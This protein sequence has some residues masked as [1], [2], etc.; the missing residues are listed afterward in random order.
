MSTLP[1]ETRDWLR[2]PGL[3]RLWES[4]R[5]R[6]EANGL[7]ATGSLRL[8]GLDAEERTA[9]SQLLGKTLTGTSVTV[10]LQELD[11]RLRTSAAEAGL[12]ATV[13]ALGQPLI[14]RRAVRANALSRRDQ[15][16]SS[17]SD[18][19]NASPLA[20]EAWAAQWYDG[21]RRSGVPRGVSLDDAVR[22]LHQATGILVLLHGPAGS[23]AR[24]RG[25]IATEATG[26]AHGLDDGTWLARLV[27]RGIALA[28]GAELPENAAGRRALWR[29]AGVTPDEVSSTVLVYGLRPDGADW[30][31]RALR[32]RADHH[33][34]SHLTLRDLHTLDLTMA[35]GTLV[36]IC[37]NPRVLEAAA[38]AA[39]TQPLVCTS[40]SA[41][42]A[43]LTLLDALVA[44]DC[45]FAYHGD[46]DWPGI[47]LANRIIRRYGARPWRMSAEDY[48]R[49]AARTQARGV[50]QLPLTGQPVDADWD[51]DL[52]PTMEALS[53]AL[54]E[55]A[56]L[57][58]LVDDLR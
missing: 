50:P 17:V 20:E 27:Q 57:D 55:E 52:A 54:H 9:V 29:L 25:E 1:A 18:A 3:Q 37:E 58:L 42:T 40:G 39:C 24:G 46:F 56:T 30:R 6:L 44:T 7:R 5:K 34:E 15:V 51:A 35:P 10:R 13:Q 32:D 19:L 11:A 8:T 4:L 38:D 33:S 36:R 23:V 16:W 48:E 21:L 31:E 28:H 45:R 12:V 41:S 49:L 2:R 43:V 22:S 47:A 14:D 26:S 53:I